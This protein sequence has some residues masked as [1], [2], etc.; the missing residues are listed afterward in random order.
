MT[1]KLRYEVLTDR[2]YR[3]TDGDFVVRVACRLEV[4]DL[5]E[6]LPLDL[7]VLI[8]RSLS[9]RGPKIE[10][11]REAAA[12]LIHALRDGD[13]LSLIA[14]GSRVEKL[15]DRVTISTIA[16]PE[17]TAAV[18]ALEAG[19]VTRMDLALEEALALLDESGA[20]LPMVLLLSDG[21]PTNQGG[22]V[23]D[24]PECESMKNQLMGAFAK[25]SVISS[26]IG[27]GDAETCLAPFL[28]SCAEAGG[29]IFYH[30]SV[31]EN[32]AARFVEELDRV[33]D[34]AVTE[35]RFRLRGL[36]GNLRRAAA[37]LPDVRALVIDGVGD[38]VIVDAGTLQ[39]GE[40]HVFL[41]E[42]V[43]PGADQPG[44]Q[45]LGEI[46]V[47]YRLD[48]ETVEGEAP[49]LLIEYTD[50][51]TLC[52]ETPHAEVTRYRE[53]YQSF[54]QTRKAVENMRGGGDTKKTRALL[55]SA[56]KTTR[57]LGLAKQTK[58]LSDLDQKLEDD[59]SLTENDLTAA[60]TGSR[61]TR[62]LS[63]T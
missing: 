1:S 15:A 61:K 7:C 16:K 6:S 2:R 27:L 19:G 5:A 63:R 4:S 10:A 26:T 56:A 35:A 46:S 55:Q 3:P 57:R 31:P 20:Y 13:R 21:A 36:N 50:D 33:K 43:T 28:E 22:Y 40:E 34:T 8:D 30:E 11:A 52:N 49:P 12:K 41:M 48:G 9:M 62:V 38:D 24:D 51:E 25:R 18:E 44:K 32:L 14:F 37:V 54:F 42:L 45:S 23:L 29:G 58:L 59:G 60:S 47:T 53:L 39:K 17:L